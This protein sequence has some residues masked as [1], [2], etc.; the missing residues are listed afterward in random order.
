MTEN[1][2]VKPSSPP[3][4]QFIQPKPTGEGWT[5]VV[6]ERVVEGETPAHCVHGK[7]TCHRCDR[8]CWLGDK[9]YEMVITGEVVGMCME[10]AIELGVA[11]HGRPIANVHD[12]LR[13]DG[14]H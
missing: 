6:L 12:H 7:V 1:P 11:E 14:P 10:C 5:I 8:F 2:F 9:S 4:F 3:P 13:K